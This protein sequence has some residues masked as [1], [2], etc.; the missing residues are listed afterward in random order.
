MGLIATDAIVNCISNC[1]LLPFLRFSPLPFPLPPGEI[2]RFAGLPRREGLERVIFHAIF[3]TVSYIAIA[4]S[5]DLF[6]ARHPGESRGPEPGPGIEIP[7]AAGLDSGFRRNDGVGLSPIGQN[8]WQW[9]VRQAKLGI[10]FR[11]RVPVG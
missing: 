1:A 5:N 9:V 2:P 10:S 3:N 4:K 7:P 6:T 11:V 8:F